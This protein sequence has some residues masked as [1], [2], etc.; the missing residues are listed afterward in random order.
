MAEDGPTLLK[1]TS[2]ITAPPY[3]DLALLLDDVLRQWLILRH[4]D[5]ATPLAT[6]CDDVECEA[7]G[8]CMIVVITD[9]L[10]VLAGHAIDPSVD[11]E[12]QARY[13]AEVPRIWPAI[14][15]TVRA[16]IAQSPGARLS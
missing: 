5:P 9:F 8:T 3:R 15:S 16:A 13:V 11:P 2:Q 10:Q 12:A 14:V 1:T 7:P 4:F 6:K